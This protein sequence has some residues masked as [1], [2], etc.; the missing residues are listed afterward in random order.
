MGQCTATAKSTGEQCQRAAIKGSNVCH[1]HGGAAPQVKKK[2][3]ERLREA[4]APAITD[5]DQTRR[6]VR[7]L[8][9]DLQD[10][11]DADEILR[12]V[13]EDEDVSSRDVLF[14]LMSLSG[15]HQGLVD[16]ILDR[17]GYPKTERRE[18]TGEGGSA[19]QV[20]SEVVE[21]TGVSDD[22]D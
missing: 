17:A 9:E 3:E 21:V 4:A 8:I 16:D 2:A 6:E 15:H 19:L 18:L 5:L 12:E 7:D 11:V 1:V 20:T 10:G 22:D 14:L 13:A